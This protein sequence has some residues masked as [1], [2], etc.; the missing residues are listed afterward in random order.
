M[1]QQE[2]DILFPKI[3]RIN[4]SSENQY[5]INY[6]VDIENKYSIAET[7]QEKQTQLFSYD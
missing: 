7:H 6:D 1:T 5:D 3:S 2:I 4:K